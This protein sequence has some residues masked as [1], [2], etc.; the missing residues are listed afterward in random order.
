MTITTFETVHIVMNWP[1]FSMEIHNPL[2]LLSLFHG[3]NPWLLKPP[4]LGVVLAIL[5]MRPQLIN[6]LSGPLHIEK[7][8][9]DSILHPPKRTIHKATFNPSSCVAQNYNI[10]EYLAQAPCVMSTL[11]FLQHCPSQHRMLLDAIGTVD[12]ESSNH[13]MFNLDNY[14][15]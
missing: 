9:F 11:E 8:M 12:P 6:P 10:V 7:P 15:S 1:K 4:L 13:I 3:N 5:M 14:A 2:C